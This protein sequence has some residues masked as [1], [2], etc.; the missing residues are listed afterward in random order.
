MKENG[1]SHPDKIMSDGSID[2]NLTIL[3]KIMIMEKYLVASSGDTL[4]SKVSGRFGH[5]GYFL[6][7][8]PLTMEFEIVMGVSKDEDQKIGKFITPAIKKVIVGNIGPSSYSEAL[9]YGC[10]VYL[11][12][13]MSVNEAVRKVSKDEVP[14]LKEPTIKKSIHSAR[15]ATDGD[16]RRGEGYGTGNGFGSGQRDGSGRGTGRV[17]GGGMGRGMGGGRGR[18]GRGVVR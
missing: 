3:K 9:S 13:N 4:D 6:I 10:K 8:D 14:E 12:R 15:K 17:M 5:S 18:G 11:C 1:E 7:I 16:G 2:D